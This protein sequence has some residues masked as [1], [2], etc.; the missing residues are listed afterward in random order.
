MGDK[1]APT[2]ARAPSFR[3]TVTASRRR[4]FALSFLMLFVELALIRWSGSNVLYLSYFSNF[5]L[6]GSFLGIGIGFLRAHAPRDLFPWAPVALL[7]LV[8]FVQ[9]AG[10]EV[11]RSGSDLIY[12][13]RLRPSGLPTWLVLPIIFLIVAFAME[14][15]AEGV[16]RTF[17]K[18]EPLDAYRIDIL[19]SISGIVAFAAI[20]FTGAPPIVWG[21]IAVG[22]L[23][24]LAS[25]GG[26]LVR[27]G[28]GAGVLAL[29][30][31]EMLPAGLSWSPYYKVEVKPNVRPG[32]TD[33]T[34]NGIPHQSIA[35]VDQRRLDSPIYFEPYERMTR[36]PGR[37]LIVG[38]GNGTDV[39][40]ALAAG[41]TS[42][43]AVEIDPRLQ[44]IGATMHPNRP[45]QD[46]RVT[47]VIDDGRA[48][49]ERSSKRYDTILFALPDS[50]TL[51]AGQSSLRLESY[52]F[53]IDAMRSARAHLAPDGVFA[54]YNY[55]REQWLIDRLAGTLR[56]VYGHP[57]CIDEVGAFGKLAALTIGLE[58]DGAQ[59][60]QTWGPNGI[61]P[62]PSTDDHPF[63]YLRTK[64]IPGFYLLTIGLILAAS[65]ALVRGAA[66]R[67]SGMR[68]YL[69]LFFMGA[70]F[71]LLE[72]KNVVQFA[73]LFGTTWFVNALVFVGILLAVVVAIEIASRV[74]LP[75][76][77]VLY[78]ALFVTVAISFAVPPHALL[79]LP[80]W[81]RLATAIP[82]AFA[83]ITLANLIFAQRFKDTASST[84]AFGANLLGAMAGGV[85]EYVSLVTGFRALLV[86][87]AVIYLLALAASPRGAR[88]FSSDAPSL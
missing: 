10:V 75:R 77:S 83:P 84:T 49:L 45:Y 13:G 42:I 60:A 51:V 68:P 69:D 29:L 23:L 54:M 65:L 61:V 21:V 66:G 86:L 43:D 72:T 76:A 48:F 18:L 27:A 71:L 12:F 2:D 57:P 1:Q 24:V 58:R 59:C 44:R 87:V 56:T 39:A 37:V 19:G 67:L 46:P 11:N 40:I 73:L 55:Y 28:A 33:I 35:S 15:I 30:V 8:V 62:A 41:A 25:G 78:A 47:A 20:S 4:L 53:T 22:G 31:I 85:L 88:Q 5:V 6:L 14:T 16:A 70:A 36:P 9:L 82:L 17:A 63:V 7:A 3:V 50:L 74:K 34:V 80:F 52:L 64:A 26:F 79:G 81:A 32:N 38:A